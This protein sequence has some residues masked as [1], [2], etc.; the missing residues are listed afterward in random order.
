[1]KRILISLGLIAVSFG[2]SLFEI[3]YVKSKTDSCLAQIEEIDRMTVSG[4]TAKAL[5]RCRSLESAWERDVKKIDVLLIHD[6]VDSVGADISRMR[7][8]LENGNADMYF[9]ESANAK[10]GLASIKGSEYPFLENIM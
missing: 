10:K 1:M 3:G 5:E 2:A 9:S 7:V 4:E 8:H 6:Y